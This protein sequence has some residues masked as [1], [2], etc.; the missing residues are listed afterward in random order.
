MRRDQAYIGAHE[1]MI[2]KDEFD[3]AQRLL[4]RSERARRRTNDWA[5]TGLIRCGECGASVTA[6]RRVNKYGRLYIYYHCSKRKRGV[7]CAQR[8]LR[9]ERL[10]EQLNA[11]LSRLHLEDA[12]CAWAF[13]WVDT[14][15]TQIHESNSA[16]IRSLKNRLTQCEQKLTRLTDLRLSGLIE[17]HEFS[18]R[19]AALLADKL[20]SQRQVDRSTQYGAER[21]ELS[22]RTFFLANQ[23]PKHFAKANNAEKREILLA[24][25]S[26]YSLRDG[27]LRTE[28]QK[29]FSLVENGGQNSIAK[30]RWERIG[31]FFAE[32]PS[33]IQWPAFCKDPKV[34]QRL[35]RQLFKRVGV[36]PLADPA[37]R[38]RRTRNPAR[39]A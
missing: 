27:I 24:V 11:L 25:G 18:E 6:E 23:A 35:K 37:R 31:T 13:K 17:D 29:P 7:V 15:F 26:N 2:T 22:S 14:Q 39:A 10:E 19:R 4:G 33:A 38:A 3:V 34:L 28:L 1:P 16:T 5:Y 9:V 21:F 30:S 32:H 20:Q 12:L 36:K 8:T